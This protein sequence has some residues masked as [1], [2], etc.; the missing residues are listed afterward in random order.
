[1]KVTT[2]QIKRI[3]M[4]LPSYLKKHYDEKAKVVSQ[5]TEDE[6]KTSTK[7]LTYA[8]ANEMIHWLQF[9][10]KMATDHFA[11]FDKKNKQ[12][13]YILSIC[14]Q[15]GWVQYSPTKRTNFVHLPSLG[16]WLHKYGYLHK[17][18]KDYTN[19]ELPKL[20]SQLEAIVTK[21]GERNGNA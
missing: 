8:Q 3:H 5:F 10:N 6:D 21:K 16:S 2:E 11:A 20:I 18:L 12:H 15:I 9:G 4:L 7:D 17:P 13:M 19:K 14:H 1:M